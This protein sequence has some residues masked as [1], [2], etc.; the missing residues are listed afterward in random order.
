MAS[1]ITCRRPSSRRHS[2]QLIARAGR[3]GPLALL[4]ALK[5]YRGA[6]IGAFIADALTV[7]GVPV[8]HVTLGNAPAAPSSCPPSP[9]FT[10]GR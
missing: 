2:I 5:R 1:P 4:S 7:R 10:T 8:F 6:V 3:E 9:A